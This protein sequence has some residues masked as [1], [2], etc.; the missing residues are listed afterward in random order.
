MSVFDNYRVVP[1]T[2]LFADADQRLLDR[3]ETFHSTYPQIFGEFIHYAL[4]L[5]NTGSTRGSAWLIIN[6]V[7]WEC[8]IDNRGDEPFLINNDYIALYARLALYYFRELFDGFFTV[9]SMKA[10]RRSSRE[11]CLRLSQPDPQPMSLS[12]DA[13]V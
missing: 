11:E 13:E 9:R 7:R 10:S 3:F 6:R 4:E 5:R 12:T 1:R 2:G 8:A